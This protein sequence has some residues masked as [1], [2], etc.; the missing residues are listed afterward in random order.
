MQ[1]LEWSNYAVSSGGTALRT[2]GPRGSGVVRPRGSC[3][4]GEDPVAGQ[5]QAGVGLTLS[6]IVAKFALMTA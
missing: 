6:E 5:I 2:F 3:E 4:P 1:Y